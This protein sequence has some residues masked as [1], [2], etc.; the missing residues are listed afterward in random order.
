MTDKTKSKGLD[1]PSKKDKYIQERYAEYQK[2]WA[3][4]P[5]Q[6]PTHVAITDREEIPVHYNVAASAF[7]FEEKEGH[8]TYEVVGHFNPNA[9]ENLLQKIWRMMKEESLQ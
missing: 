3:E 1:M 6:P 2:K 7:D 4:N 9:R 8:T 5:P